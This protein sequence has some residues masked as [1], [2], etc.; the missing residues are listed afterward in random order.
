MQIIEIYI[1]RKTQGDNCECLEEKENVE[2]EAEI[3]F[4]MLTFCQEFQLLH[5]HTH[6]CNRHNGV[7]DC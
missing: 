1:T 4:S 5:R 3:I 2:K 7:S 6:K